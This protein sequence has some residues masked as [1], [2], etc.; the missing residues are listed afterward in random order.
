MVEDGQ[1]HWISFLLIYANASIT[2][3]MKYVIH[4]KRESTENVICLC[5]PK[6]SS[7]ILT[8]SNN[9]Y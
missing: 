2:F 9:D 7:V 8:V 4:V 5:L 6:Q 3:L 1:I